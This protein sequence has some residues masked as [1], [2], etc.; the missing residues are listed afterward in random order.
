MGD[1]LHRGFHFKQCHGVHCWCVNQYGEAYSYSLTMR[2]NRLTCTQTGALDGATQRVQLEMTPVYEYMF[3]ISIEKEYHIDMIHVL[4]ITSGRDPLRSSVP[5]T[6]PSGTEPLVCTRQRYSVA[7]LFAQAEIYRIA[8]ESDYVTAEDLALLRTGI[9][10]D[11]C[12][13][14]EETLRDGEGNDVS[15]D[16]FKLKGKRRDEVLSTNNCLKL[17]LSRKIPL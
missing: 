13:Q 4:F 17:R 11:P 3:V 10:S 14:C 5:V 9:Y 2:K 15:L 7:F 16:Q 1:D 6:C 12:D 8:E